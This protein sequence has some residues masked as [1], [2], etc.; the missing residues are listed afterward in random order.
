MKMADANSWTGLRLPEGAQL[1]KKEVFTY[2]VREQEFKIELFE[3]HDG[4]Y[5]A[6]GVPEND[7]RLIIYGSSIVNDK[8]TALQIV[9]DKIEREA[10][11]LDFLDNDC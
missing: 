9:V 2:T 10:G 3:Q 1:V 5:Y 4:T 6:I 11:N 7:E 8:R